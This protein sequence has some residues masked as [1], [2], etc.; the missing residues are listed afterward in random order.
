VE[1][2]KTSTGPNRGVVFVAIDF[3]AAS[4][5]AIREA[6]ARAEA[7]GRQ[8][9]VCHVVPNL[10][11]A[12]VLFPQRAVAQGNA[13]LELHERASQLLVERTRELTGREPGDFAPIVVEG[14]PYGAIVAQ[15][16]SAGADLIVLARRVAVGWRASS[17]PR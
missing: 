13:Q 16:E 1:S 14:T 11:G 2:P 17:T 5:Q 10:L 12:N 4:D 8:L 6:H 3:S 7:D 15:A 9:V